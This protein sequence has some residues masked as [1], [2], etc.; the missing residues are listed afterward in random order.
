ML[1]TLK[2]SAIGSIIARARAPMANGREIRRSSALKL[3]L[4]RALSD[5]S[6]SG[7]PFTPPLAFIEVRNGSRRSGPPNDFAICCRSNGGSPADRSSVAGSACQALSRVNRAAVPC[8][9]LLPD[10]V[11]TL[12]TDDA[13][14]P[15]SAE[16]RFVI[17]A[18]CPV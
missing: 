6:G 13:E 12:T 15:R 18:W 8:R 1:K 3:S 14:W 9:S 10:W 7:T 4:K 11:I 2:I 16:K 5:T 17:P